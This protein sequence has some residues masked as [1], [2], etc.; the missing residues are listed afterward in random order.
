MKSFFTA[1]VYKIGTKIMKDIQRPNQISMLQ[2]GAVSYKNEKKL[3]F[4]CSRTRIGLP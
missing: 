4:A 2:V 3:S 1:F